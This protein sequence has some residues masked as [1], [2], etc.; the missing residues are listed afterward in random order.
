MNDVQDEKSKF[1]IT[2]DIDEVKWITGF[3][4]GFEIPKT[5]REHARLKRWCMENC[6]DVICYYINKQSYDSKDNI[7]FY[8]DEDAMAYK[9]MWE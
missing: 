5:F 6:E 1:Y 2:T 3:A 4:R 8:S 9:L 7:Y